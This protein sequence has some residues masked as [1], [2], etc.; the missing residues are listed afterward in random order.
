MQVQVVNS[1]ILWQNLRN[2]EA[3]YSWQLLNHY[4]VLLGRFCPVDQIFAEVMEA[5]NY[6]KMSCNFRKKS[7]L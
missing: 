4:F 3:S 1:R 7:N 2:I 6:K 5:A